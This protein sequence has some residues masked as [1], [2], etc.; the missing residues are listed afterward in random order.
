MRMELAPIPGETMSLSDIDQRLGALE[1]EFKVLF[2]SSK[3]GGGYFK[4]TEAFQRIAEEMGAMKE[5][6]SFILAHQ[7]GSSAA[8]RRI[9]DAVNTL[10]TGS[11]E[12]KEWDEGVIR[13]LVDMITVLSAHRI[14][15]CLR[16][17]MEIEQELVE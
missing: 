3:E 9:W 16:G 15:V 5:K 4:H 1:R 8:N 17:G 2:Q 11:E 6:K 13:Q 14:R 12:I 10:N 7:E